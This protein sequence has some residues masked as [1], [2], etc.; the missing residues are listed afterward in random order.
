MKD[1]PVRGSLWGGCFSQHFTPVALTHAGL[2]HR[3][4]RYKFFF[5]EPT[6]KHRGRFVEVEG[7]KLNLVNARVG[8]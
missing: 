3:R 1:V 4:Q 8:R 5:M 7:I 6:E 2:P